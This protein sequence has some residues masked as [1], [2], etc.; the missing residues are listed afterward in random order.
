MK[1]HRR[2]T[3]IAEEVILN[4]GRGS[5]PAFVHGTTGAKR[6]VGASPTGT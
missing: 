5:G 1:A 3:G 4:L 6:T 2:S